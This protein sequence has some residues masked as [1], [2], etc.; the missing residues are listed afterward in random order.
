MIKFA[1]LTVYE[2]LGYLLPGAV[3]VT[4]FIIIAWTI[5]APC[6]ELPVLSPSFNLW[7]VL[8]VVAYYAGHAV[9]SAGNVLLD[10]DCPLQKHLQNSARW[11]AATKWIDRLFGERLPDFDGPIEALA[12]RK[13]KKLLQLSWNDPLD[14]VWVKRLADEAL[15]QLGVASE[16]DVYIYREGFYRGSCLSLLVFGLAVCFRA[17]RGT[18]TLCFWNSPHT[19]GSSELVSLGVLCIAAAWMFWRRFD[20]FGQL[21]RRASIVGFLLLDKPHPSKP[22]PGADD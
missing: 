5:W 4:A 12:T 9:Q 7:A 3:L 22:T 8:I 1:Q 19:I 10:Y 11:Q 17:A 15:V 21:H 6:E 2:G 20:H 16:R 14:F 18:T 13:A